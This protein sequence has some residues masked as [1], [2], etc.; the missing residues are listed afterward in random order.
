AAAV[1]ALRY[2]A[3]DFISKPFNVVEILSIVERSMERRSFNLKIRDLLQKVKAHHLLGPDGPG[4]ALDN[5]GK[6][7]VSTLPKFE[8]TGDSSHSSLPL[9]FA[10]RTRVTVDYMDF[11]KVLV[12]ILESKEP[13]TYGHSERV[14]F[15]A[16]IMAQDMNLSSEER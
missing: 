1:E 11:F 13:Y 15:Y 3:M 10:P 8:T 16:E 4:E 7:L 9:E 14:S 6:S 2:G 12:Y 5:L